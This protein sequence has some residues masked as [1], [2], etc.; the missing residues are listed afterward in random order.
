M[1]ILR[2]LI[3]GGLFCVSACS[4]LSP[5]AE[6]IPEGDELKA[7]VVGVPYLLKINILGG[8]VIDGWYESEP[9]YKPGLVTPNDAGI[10]LRN[11]RLPESKTES[12]L[13]KTPLYNGNCIEV[14]G[15]PIK[16]GELK[17][18]IDGG[19]YGSMI[20]PASEFS[21]EYKINVTQP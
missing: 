15:T 18:K 5:K 10:F 8:R 4:M 2:S 9:D 6:Y 19:M 20:A 14:Y 1:W 3:L 17:I 13:P 21:K 11:C 12:F 7:A 16:A